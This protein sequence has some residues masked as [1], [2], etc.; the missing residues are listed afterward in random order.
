VRISASNFAEEVD[1][2]QSRSGLHRRDAL[3]NI[4][5]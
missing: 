3:A 4:E 2:L 1:M 5:A